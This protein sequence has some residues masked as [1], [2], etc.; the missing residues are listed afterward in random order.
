MGTRAP[1]LLSATSLRVTATVS[2]GKE[3]GTLTVDWKTSLP[4]PSTFGSPALRA[5]LL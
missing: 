5:P 4:P 3:S 2:T 1:H